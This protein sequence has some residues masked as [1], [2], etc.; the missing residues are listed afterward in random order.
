MTL[1]ASTL[2]IYN[3]TIMPNI[4]A[5]KRINLSVREEEL[6][7]LEDLAVEYGFKGACDIVLS[8]VRL[9]LRIAAKEREKRSRRKKTPQTLSEEIESMF[10]EMEDF[11]PTPQNT[12]P[13]QIRR[14]RKD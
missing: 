8:M 10:R 4:S 2:K 9:F 1:M 3:L 7:I 13:R 11:E 5:R 12:L 14:P 6:S